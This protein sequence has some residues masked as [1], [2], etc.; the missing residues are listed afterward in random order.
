MIRVRVTIR[1]IFPRGIIYSNTISNLNPNPNPDSNLDTVSNVDVSSTLSTTAKAVGL[2]LGLGVGV[3]IGGAMSTA[4][5]GLI[6]VS[7][8][9]KAGVRAPDPIDTEGEAVWGEG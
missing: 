1:F 2:G 3:G 8:D 4:R 5:A 9:V 6:A 7:T